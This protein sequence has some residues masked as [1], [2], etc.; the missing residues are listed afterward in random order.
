MSDDY[1]PFGAAAGIAA[2]D[3]YEVAIADRRAEDASAGLAEWLYWWRTVDEWSSEHARP[4]LSTD[5][6]TALTLARNASTHRQVTNGLLHSAH[7]GAFRV[8]MTRL[9]QVEPEM[10][11]LPGDSLPMG[12]GSAEKQQRERDAYE[13]LLACRSSQDAAALVRGWLVSIASP[14]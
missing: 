11:W 12:R 7:L 10:A 5:L 8:G 3:R 1:G 14:S 2:L 4:R 6:V 9:G 13:R